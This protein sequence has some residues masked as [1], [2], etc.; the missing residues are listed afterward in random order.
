M[1]DSHQVDPCGRWAPLGVAALPGVGESVQSLALGRCD[2]GLRGPRAGA[3]APRPYLDDDELVTV[4]SDDVDFTHS[5]TMPVS[6]DHP[7]TCALDVTGRDPLAGATQAA[8]A[9]AHS[10]LIWV[11]R[12]KDRRWMGQGPC[13]AMAARCIGVGYPLC[14]LNP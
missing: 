9:Q 14:W 5:G 6:G 1:L 10:R 4:A 12:L 7:E 13:L 3:S 2:A 11:G 8:P